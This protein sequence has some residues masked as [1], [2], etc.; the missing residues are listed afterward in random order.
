[1]EPARVYEAVVRG[2]WSPQPRDVTQSHS[3]F[4]SNEQYICFGS[5]LLQKVSVEIRAPQIPVSNVDAANPIGGQALHRIQ[6][7]FLGWSD[8]EDSEGYENFGWW[9]LQGDPENADLIRKR[10]PSSTWTRIA[11]RLTFSPLNVSAATYE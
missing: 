2:E 5:N 3:I 4:N 1:V 7:P 10:Q 9:D 6:R 8:Y 11:T